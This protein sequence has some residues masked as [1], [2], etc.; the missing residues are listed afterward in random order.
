MIKDAEGTQLAPLGIGEYAF[1]VSE[2]QEKINKFNTSP[3]YL[4]PLCTYWRLAKG[5][6]A[7]D[8]GATEAAQDWTDYDGNPVP[9]GDGPDIGAAEFCE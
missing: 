6:P 4:R 8:V 5:S 1:G 3:M 2:S 9:C 7:I